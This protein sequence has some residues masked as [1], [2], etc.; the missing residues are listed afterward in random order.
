MVWWFSVRGRK[1]AHGGS[2]P[3]E[4]AEVEEVT[5]SPYFS[6]SK[7]HLRPDDLSPSLGYER[8]RAYALHVAKDGPRAGKRHFAE[9]QQTGSSDAPEICSPTYA[10]EDPCLSNPLSPGRHQFSFHAISKGLD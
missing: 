8:Q 6:P 2:K 10:D 4:R 9:S 7:T 1:E 3:N 5:A